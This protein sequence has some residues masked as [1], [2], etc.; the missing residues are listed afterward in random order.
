MV[1]PLLP[2][3]D[4]GVTFMQADVALDV[5]SPSQVQVAI[6]SSVNRGSGINRNDNV[7]S[8]WGRGRGM[9]QQV[10]R[11]SAL[12]APPHQPSRTHAR[13]H[14][15]AWN[16]PDSC[17]LNRLYTATLAPGVCTPVTFVVPGN[18]ARPYRGVVTEYWRLEG[19]PQCDPP[20]PASPQAL[21]FRTLWTRDLG[22]PIPSGGLCAG[23]QSAFP[24]VDNGVSPFPLPTSDTPIPFV[25]TPPLPRSN[26][27]Y[28]TDLPL[29]FTTQSPGFC[30]TN[31]SIFLNDAVIVRP[32]PTQVSLSVFSGPGATTFTMEV[33]N[34]MRINTPTGPGFFE[35]CASARDGN[36]VPTSPHYMGSITFPLNDAVSTLCTNGQW[37]QS[38]NILQRL[39]AQGVDEFQLSGRLFTN[40]AFPTSR[41]PIAPAPN[42]P[43]G[44][45]AAAAAAAASQATAS[46]STANTGLSIGAAGVAVAA[47]GLLG[48]G[49]LFWRT[50]ALA[51]R[52]EEL[53][54]GGK[55]PSVPEWGAAPVKKEAFTLPAVGTPN[56]VAGAS[57]VTVVSQ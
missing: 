45:A 38:S 42:T 50:Q 3:T 18:D 4:D 6:F 7:L 14:M 1:F 22:N 43:A 13:S 17:S 24:G 5:C 11:G 31:V 12:A 56:P 40:R 27:D 54:R 46:Q 30:N 51:A 37:T 35:G 49:L 32:R 41:T 8:E 53:A 25:P 16:D 36:G 33:Y 44:A 48:M 20:P 23:Y 15:L 29:L 55:G 10:L 34:N 9:P 47:L 57:Q 52:L 28:F 39:A 21:T 26:F 19:E 2:V